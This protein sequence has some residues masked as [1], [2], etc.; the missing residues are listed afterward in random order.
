MHIISDTI[1]DSDADA[2]SQIMSS[3]QT[4]ET[5]KQRDHSYPVHSDSDSG[6]DSD[7]DDPIEQYADALDILNS[8]SDRKS[9][10]N[11][12]TPSWLNSNAASVRTKE[13]EWV[14]GT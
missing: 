3:T 1:N 10:L 13:D 12:W 4:L 2:N 14:M 5:K 7:S 11:L 9:L 8:S 6:S